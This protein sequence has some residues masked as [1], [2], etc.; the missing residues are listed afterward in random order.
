V[1][2]TRTPLCGPSSDSRC[3]FGGPPAA[4]SLT[5][6]SLCLLLPP[7]P[8]SARWDRGFGLSADL[9]G[10]VLLTALDLQS[11][12][13]VA[14]PGVMETKETE[15]EGAEHQEIAA[16]TATDSAV[17]D[18]PASA[19]ASASA[20]ATPPVAAASKRAK[21]TKSKPPPPPPPPPGDGTPPPPSEYLL[22]RPRREAKVRLSAY[23]DL[24]KLPHT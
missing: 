24:H 5:T 21:A 13:G 14:L 15:G 23:I 20:S 22:N 12:G 11:T 7:T 17:V 9:T 3:E 4:A 18:D 16:S 19:S 1:C 10:W 2:V 6:L 8:L